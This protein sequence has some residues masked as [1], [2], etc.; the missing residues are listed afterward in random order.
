[1]TRTVFVITLVLTLFGMSACQQPEEELKEKTKMADW[2]Y[3]G[4]ALPGDEPVMFGPERISTQRNERD[5]AI[6]PDGKEIFYSYALPGFSFS[7]ILSFRYTD[8]GWSGPRVASFSG[9]Y[10]DLEPALSPD[11][12]K[13]FFIS[14]RQVGEEDSTRDWNIWF[15]AREDEKDWGA[16][17]VLG[18]PVN[19]EGNEFYPSVAQ[20]GNLYFTA[21]NRTDSHGGEDIYCSEFADGNY[22]APINLGPGVN[23]RHPEFNAFIS[24]DESY[25]LFS[26]WGREDGLGGGDLYIAFRDE[27]GI[28]QSAVNLGSAINSDKLDYCPCVTHDGKLLFF[29]SQRL[30]PRLNDTK[31]KEL[32]EVTGLEDGPGNGLGDIYWVAFDP[33]KW[34]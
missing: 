2:Q 11:G 10:N 25:L 5:F 18:P 34:K 27:A 23:S 13:L 20:N 21:E 19:D 29:T 14:R 24:P 33:A 1:M 17:M 15:S 16:P 31:R 9:M 26:S 32:K 3:F 7:T 4:E 30:D 6:S 8:A 12:N 22:S 28:W